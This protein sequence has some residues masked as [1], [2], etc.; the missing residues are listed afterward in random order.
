V[1]SAEFLDGLEIERIS[2]GVRHHDG[3]RLRTDCFA[4][5]RGDCIV[6][7]QFDVD[8]DWLQ[9]IL[10][11]GVDRCREAHRDGEHF[12]AGLERTLVKLRTRERAE[13]NEV[14]TG[15]AVDEERRTSADVLRECALEGL[16]E[17]ACGEPSVE[18]RVDQCSKIVAVEHLSGHRDRRSAWHERAS[19]VLDLGK[20]T[21]RGEN[22]FTQHCLG[23]FHAMP[24]TSHE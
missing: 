23:V 15:T 13:S 11:N 8:D 2:E 3:S 14:R 20:S 19:G 17:S 21:H 7:S 24:S 6:G 16:G 5:S 22:L 18:A 1:L 12:V 4:Q 10:K 9:A